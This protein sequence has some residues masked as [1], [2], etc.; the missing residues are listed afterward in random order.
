M[1]ADEKICPKCAEAVK[2][3][4][5]ICKH[6]G[7]GFEAY[8]GTPAVQPQA[9][10]HKARNGCLG[11]LVILGALA[12]IG[13]LSQHGSSSS[14]ASNSSSASSS[15]PLAITAKKL[16]TE[17]GA[18]EAAAQQK[19]GDIPLL[20]SGRINSINLD[21]TNDTYLVLSG[22]NMFLGPQAHLTDASKAKAPSLSKGQAV[23][24]RC[25]GAKYIIGTVML[26][27]CDLQ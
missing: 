11:I 26:S 23:A 12:A 9:K 14:P 6:C 21:M 13:S 7:H 24:L 22:N 18:N 5:T 8:P 20:V 1:E 25:T 3:K 27:D 15:P 4:A 17:Y 2:A 10:S 19:Y 16:D